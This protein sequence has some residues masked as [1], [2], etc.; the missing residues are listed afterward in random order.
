MWPVSSPARHSEVDG[1]EIVSR[2]VLSTR[3]LP[4]DCVWDGR[5]EVRTSPRPSL[6]AHNAGE[7]QEIEVG[8][9]RWSIVVGADHL[10]PDAAAAVTPPA[11]SQTPA[12]TMTLNNPLRFQLCIG[13]H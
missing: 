3:S 6:T 12:A 2:P 4:Q 9:D 5:V 1:H 11:Q 8:A 10:N 13:R 7:G